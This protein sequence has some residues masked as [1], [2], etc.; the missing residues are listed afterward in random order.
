MSTEAID[1]GR[2]AVVA[3]NHRLSVDDRTKALY[4]GAVHYWRLDRE[5]WSPILDEVA[6]M[7][8]TT[9]SI[10]IPWEVH[11]R[12]RGEFDFAGNKDIDAFLTLIE[13]KGFDIVVRPGPQINSELTWFGYP[14][15]I[16][17]DPE[18]QALNA[19]GTPAVLTQ[20]PRPI[21]AVSYAADKFFDETALWYDAI[22]PILA[23]HAYPNGRI[24]AA[25]VD[26]EMA[27]FFHVNAY[28]ADFHPAS[29]ARY[30][31]FLTERYGSIDAL[32][33]AYG[34]AHRSFDEVEPPRRF[35]ARERVEIPWYTDWIAYRERYLVDSMS[36]LAE[37]MRE[38]GLD[39]IALFHNYPHPLGPGGAVSGFTTPF[40]LSGLE[41]R[42]DFVGFDVY[43]RKELYHHVK[44]VLSYVVGTSRFPYIPE[45]IAGVWPWY[46][47][48][49]DLGD[50]EFVTKAALMQGI[51]GFSRYM[52]VE[53]DR[54]LDSPIRRDGRV[55]ED[56][57]TMF[58]R[59]NRVAV[60][61]D[62]ADLHRQAD[63]LLLANRDYDRLEAA[64]VLVSFPGDFLET[65]SGF[66]EYP[67]FMTVC[68]RPLGFEEPIQVA[69][70]DW[71]AA[72]YAGLNEAGLAYLISDTALPL[73]R[74]RRFK[75]VVVS[76]FEYMAADVQRKLVEF[77]AGGGTVVLGPRLPTLNERM[78]PDDTLKRAVEADGERFV[79]V[80]GFAEAIDALSR[81][82]VVRF[83][84]NDT[85]LDVAVHA[86]D[87]GSDRRIVYVANPSADPIA[88]EVSVT[89]PVTWERELWTGRAV[90]AAGT[91][92][93]ELPPYTVS[94]YECRI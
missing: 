37:M 12:S 38:R 3:D 51:K 13:E 59:A 93:E 54:W 52:L 40:D 2:R 46:L 34:T 77:A 26:N 50:E 57:A 86:P 83:A 11:E 17:A 36:R 18:L 87:D 53:R 47:H 41:Q 67:T 30:R 66:S 7:G 85:R 1:A 71:F 60:E 35:E 55:R 64:S 39:E 45:F 84:R 15:R 32:N 27:Y 21:P 81:L 22:C 65:P 16:L 72:A 82:D 14:L 5:R 56:H 70:A 44:T 76:S 23:R 89:P 73:E 48:P 28:A 63:V 31:L 33:E 62:F 88:A 19:Q 90:G 61:A 91:L 68:E 80:D 4:G 24:V 74:W 6:R 10:Y 78:Q 94:I 69:E 49:G 25:Q 75:A 20:V 79:L 58:E 92:R 43:S 29:C 9:I 42:L 8:F